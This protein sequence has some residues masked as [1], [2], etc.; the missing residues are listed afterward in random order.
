MSLRFVGLKGWDV[1]SP[2][3]MVPDISNDHSDFIFRL[4]QFKKYFSWSAG[5]EDEGATSLRN[6][7]NYSSKRRNVISWKI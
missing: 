7:R 1:S 6:A 4:R 5:P 3:K 2:E